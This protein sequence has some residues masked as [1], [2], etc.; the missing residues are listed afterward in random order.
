M[1]VAEIDPLQ[2]RQPSDNSSVSPQFLQRW[3]PRAMTGAAVTQ[4]ELNSLLEAARWAPSCFNAQPWRYAYVLRSSPSWD[5]LFSTLAEQNQAWVQQA[6][7]MIAVISR[8]RYQHNDKPA[9]THSFDAGAS[10]MS[11]ALQAQALGLVTHGMQGFDQDAARSALKV[12]QLYDLPC[13]IAVG[14]PGAIDDLPEDLA[15]KESPST[16]K[17]LAE[18][19]FKDHFDG[20][21]T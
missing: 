13:I 11:L 5:A 7:A 2:H 14:R 16:R 10:W 3:S 6:G 1:N 21:D 12:P 20:V 15:D 9:P 4:E 17:P 18:I 8:K 19:M